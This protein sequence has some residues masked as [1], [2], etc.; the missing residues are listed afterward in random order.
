M[1]K[2][3]IK[4]LLLFILLIFIVSTLS[5]SCTK[6]DKTGPTTDNS[7]P[8]ASVKKYTFDIMTDIY[9]WYKD[10]P[11]NIEAR[12]I[13]TAEAYF[14]TLLVDIDRWSWMM[15][16]QEYLNSESGIVESYGISIGQPIDYYQDYSVRVRYVFPNSPMSENGVKRGY[17]LTHL[18]GTPVKTLI[19]NE[20]FNTVYA[21]TTN[22]FTFKDYSGNSF[23]FSATKRVLT[24]RSALKTAVFGPEEFPTLNHNVG[25]FHYLSFKTGMLD[26]IHNAMKVFKNSQI[27]ELI[28][29]LRYNGGGDGKASSLL[30]NYIAPSSAQNKILARKE[31]NDRYRSWDSQET[32]KTIIDRVD[33][34][35][36]L[37]RLFILTTKGSASASE[38]ILNGLDPLMDVVQVGSTT[39]G[40][41]NGMYVLPFPEGDY[42][43]PQYVFLPICFFSVNS[44]GYGH[45]LD[46]ISPDYYRPDDLYHDFGVEDDWIKSIIQYIT[47]GTFPPLPPKPTQTFTSMPRT[48]ITLPEEESGYGVYKVKV[49]KD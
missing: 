2:K 6:D 44:Q 31:H 47:E 16:G 14:D 20:T 18:N 24:T 11:T 7:D 34:A 9:Y 10:V 43:T 22:L 25:Y 42:K 8:L 29:D 36:E 49:E 41:P 39:Y 40:K 21:Q 37:E 23:S 45:Y 27:K 28:L 12:A 15:T 33:G 32:T 26:D 4:Q 38:V 1:I 3:Y 46:G 17:E 48:K 35:L 19:E 30:A 5:L 13:K